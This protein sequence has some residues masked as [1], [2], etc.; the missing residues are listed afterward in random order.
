MYQEMVNARLK[1]LEGNIER[2]NPDKPIEEQVDLLP[3]DHKFE[4]PINRLVLGKSIFRL[5]FVKTKVIKYN[6]DRETTRCWSV[7]KSHQGQSD[8][9]GS[10]W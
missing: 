7:W 3:Y 1:L 6:C 4:F 9:N 2:I 8:W 5:F 10:I